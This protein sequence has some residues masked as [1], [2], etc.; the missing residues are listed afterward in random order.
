MIIPD[1]DKRGNVNVHD[2]ERGRFLT[3]MK[4]KA[5][6]RGSAEIPL[7]LPNSAQKRVPYVS[8]ISVPSVKF[9]IP[10]RHFFNCASSSA[11]HWRSRPRGQSLTCCEKKTPLRTAILKSLLFCKHFNFV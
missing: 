10:G 5:R 1:Y 3:V 11:M 4:R 6:L 7:A 9:C 8:V 2:Q